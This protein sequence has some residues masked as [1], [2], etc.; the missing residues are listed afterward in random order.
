MISGI[1]A[2]AEGYQSMG[3]WSAYG[4]SKGSGSGMDSNAANELRK[5][6]PESFGID[7]AW[8]SRLP[9]SSGPNDLP[10]RQ[11]LF[12]Y[13]GHWIIDTFPF[14]TKAKERVA[15]PLFQMTH[16]H[17]HSH[18]LTKEGFAWVPGLMSALGGNSRWSMRNRTKTLLHAQQ[19]V[20]SLQSSAVDEHKVG[21]KGAAMSALSAKKQLAQEQMMAQRAGMNVQSA[22]GGN[23]YLRSTVRLHVFCNTHAPTSAPTTS[24]PTTSP[25]S[26]NQ[27]PSCKC[28]GV[29]IDGKEVRAC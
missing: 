9:P 2:G 7:H 15:E 19:E 1:P 12:P 26:W 14:R 16:T 28:S 22:E 17:S 29:A 23:T 27:S 5:L 4:E 25:T 10:K 24:A 3:V 20:N 6:S 8:Y 21:Y 11:Y 18:A 13:E